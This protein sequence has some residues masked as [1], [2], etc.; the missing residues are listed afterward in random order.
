M[1]MRKGP[2]VLLVRGTALQCQLAAPL[3]I[4]HIWGEVSMGVK[5]PV[6]RFPGAGFGFFQPQ[7]DVNGR[8]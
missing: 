5:F 1:G 2:R 6:V 3:A 7:M 4:P 8:G